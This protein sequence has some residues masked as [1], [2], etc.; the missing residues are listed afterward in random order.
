MAAEEL[1]SQLPDRIRQT[2]SGHT[3]K[4][5]PATDLQS[6][7]GID[8]VEGSTGAGGLDNIVRG[9]RRPPI[10]LSIESV[11]ADCQFSRIIRFQIDSTA[12]SAADAGSSPQAYGNDVVASTTYFQ[13]QKIAA[14]PVLRHRPRGSERC[15]RCE[16]GRSPIRP[17][18]QSGHMPRQSAGILLYRFDAGGTCE[19]LIGHMGGPFWAKKDAGAWSIPKG[20]YEPGELPF[21]VARREFEEELGSPVPAEEYVALGE[22]RQAS[23]KVLTVWAAEGDLDA[24]ARAATP[25]SWSGRRARAGCRS[26]PRS[27]AAPGSASRRPGSLWSAAR[28]RSSTG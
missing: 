2:N 21:D 5:N 12:S 15:R 4:Q 6:E 24:A 17:A 27:T 23:G 1:R 28:S 7:S 9:A 26:S 18:L 25:S 14:G 13:P 10:E 3:H 8:L 16:P 22:M 20:E 11:G 19:V